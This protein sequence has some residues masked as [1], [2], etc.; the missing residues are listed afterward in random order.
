MAILSSHPL[1]N[2]DTHKG[3]LVKGKD[4]Q[5]PQC[6]RKRERYEIEEEEE[7]EEEGGGGE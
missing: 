5:V 2:G 4:V 1:W 7:E 3:T 6:K